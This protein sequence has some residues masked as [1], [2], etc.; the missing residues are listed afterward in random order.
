MKIAAAFAVR[1]I[2]VATFTIF[3]T[4]GAVSPS[5]L[6]A[7]AQGNNAVYAA[8]G[9]ATSPST[10][11]IDAS[12][13]TGNPGEGTDFCSIINYIYANG[14]V[15]SVGAVIDARGIALSTSNP[16][17][18]SP[19]N[20]LTNPPPATILL[21]AGVIVIDTPWILPN[22]TRIIGDR[23]NTQIAEDFSSAAFMIQM[24]SSTFCPSGCQGI[25][26]QDVTLVQWTAATVTG[27]GGIDNEFAG[28][29]SYMD[30]VV[31]NGM[32]SG[33]G[34]D[35][36]G[37]KIGAGAANSG[38]YTNFNYTAGTNC[39]GLSCPTAVCVQIQAST[40][41]IHGM[42]CTAKST[43]T[44]ATPPPAGI[45]VDAN[46]NSIEDVHFEGF[47]DGVVVGDSAAASGNVL[48]NLTGGFGLG[49]VNN[50]VHLCN[51]TAV[52]MS[53]CTTTGSAQDVTILGVGVGGG[54]GSGF[55]A[56]AVRDDV[57]G[58]IVSESATAAEATVG[59][60]VLGQPVAG[61]HTRLTDNPFTSGITSSEPSPNPSP[62][63]ATG[64]ATPT[65]SCPT[66]AIF[67]N[68]SG[69]SLITTLYVCVN[70]G[71]VGL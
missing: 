68:T 12:A 65:G 28:E 24:G 38:P 36:T 39:S 43:A 64:S 34:L 29:F 33:T 27:V 54:G 46:N 42:T 15:P 7:Q 69:S 40:R 47:Y 14:F 53:A 4:Y 2:F 32:G 63:W 48:V 9:S 52:S 56:Y 37:L 71:W 11:Y 67:S 44:D 59:M 57:T 3:L 49:P 70:G 50:V 6:Q 21:P 35:G 51:G 60:Y 30:H 5:R 26:V 45:E 13:I 23:R 18:I 16:C 61:G 62:V 25:V 20:G 1:W 41:G 10:D 8:S 66:G 17:L 22:A 19:W 31:F 58:T 55:N